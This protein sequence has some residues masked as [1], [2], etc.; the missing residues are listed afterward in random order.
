MKHI[1]FLLLFLFLNNSVQASYSFQL[2]NNGANNQALDVNINLGSVG[3]PLCNSQG[4]VA[5]SSL[6]RGSQN[7]VCNDYNGGGQR[8]VELHIPITVRVTGSESIQLAVTYQ[9]YS[10]GKDF[11]VFDLRN[12]RN[13]SMGGGS[14][15]FGQTIIMNLSDSFDYELDIRAIVSGS[16]A[17][18]SYDNGIVI[19]VT[20]P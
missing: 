19:L 6:R 9:K 18:S 16:Q 8:G 11:Q 3:L 15:V 13:Q 7:A 14:S 12:S 20:L 1:L 5:M 10:T 17:L 2:L 4:L